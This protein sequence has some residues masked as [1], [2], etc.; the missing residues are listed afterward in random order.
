MGQHEIETLIS[1]EE[2]L[3]FE[4][5][6]EEKH[7]YLAG[8]VF[9]MT[10]AS[11]PHNIITFNL[12]ATIGSQLPEGCRGRSANQMIYIEEA[13]TGFY[14]DLSI[15]GGEARFKDAKKRL[16]LNPRVIIEVLSPSTERGDRTLK[17]EIYQLIPSLTDY[18]LV[19][20]NEPLIEGWK[21]SAQG[22]WLKVRAA[23]LD[24]T[25]TIESIKIMLALAD[26]YRGVEL[27]MWIV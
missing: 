1:L 17:R 12:T 2:F 7:E 3:L 16:L 15:T 6:A 13:D 4:E 21:R 11:D 9:A 22:E 10:G 23:G 18:L 26:V 14:P 8:R 5:Q 25:L 24:D 27:P 20:Q 19:A